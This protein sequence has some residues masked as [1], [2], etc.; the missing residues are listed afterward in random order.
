MKWH[1][2]LFTWAILGGFVILYFRFWT[3]SS[4]TDIERRI[5]DF[6][7]FSFFPITRNRSTRHFSAIAVGGL[8]LS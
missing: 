5:G 2:R 4:S 1:E 7:V 6:I 8:L 3:S